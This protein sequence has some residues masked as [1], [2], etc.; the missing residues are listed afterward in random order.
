MIIDRT[1]T[2]FIDELKSSAPTP[3][4]G[5][6][7]A[8]NSAQGVALIMMV[9][10]LTV[11]NEKYTEWHSLC[12]SVLEE[13][14][15]LLDTLVK[16]VDDDAEEFHKVITAYGL[17]RSTD[18]E[19]K[20]RS[21]AI[22]EASITAAKAPLRVMKASARALELDIAI[23]GK[24]NPNVESDL[25]VA[26]RSLQAGLLSAKYNVDANLGGIRKIDPELA[27]EFSTKADELI[28]KCNA[29]IAK[30]F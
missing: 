12:N 2:D 18:E 7:S 21:R 10:N 30:V 15:T 25:F 26:A 14:Q 27:D 13:C 22:S 16:G 5:G 1:I 29:L 24:S 8:L 20:Q 9:A 4:G 6:V 17:P 3:G 28:E 23:L 11:E 19:K